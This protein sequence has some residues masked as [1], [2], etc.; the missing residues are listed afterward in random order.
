ME[1]PSIYDVFERM[2]QHILVKLNSYATNE[3]FNYHI[4]DKNNPH[5]VTA[6]QV[7]L[8][9]VDNTADM[10]K[11]ISYATQEALDGKVDKD[12]IEVLI[13]VE[14]ID[15]ICSVTVVGS[16][17]L[18]YSLNSSGTE[19]AVT[20]IGTC[21]DVDVII[22]NVYNGL[23]VT[24]IG[25]NAFWYESNLTSV[26]I[27]NSVTMIDNYAFYNCT[28][29]TSMIIPNSVT[30]IGTAA[31]CACTNLISIIL[32]SGITSIEP[33]VLSKCTSLTSITIPNGVSNIDREA[34]YGCTGLTSITIPSGV[35]SI[36]NRA[37]E[38]CTGL[39]SITIPNSVISI[40]DWAFC[41]CTGLTYVN[42]CGS[43]SM[44]NAIDIGDFNRWL[45]DA[46]I[47]YN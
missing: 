39:T 26:V 35:I 46:T 20:G 42:Y 36:A 31:F 32:S 38:N 30:R 12:D 21:T 33:A 1:N 9:D 8:G 14:D 5:G 43:E 40:G 37:F 10:D 6:E 45:T 18:R 16:K 28:G 13:T 27:P 7:G 3:T 24:S 44:W 2:W 25:D 11:P 41:E 47:S 23:P 29:L 19:Y 4:E 34:F 17:G 15:N 22:P